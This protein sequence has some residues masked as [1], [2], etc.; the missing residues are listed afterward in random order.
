MRALKE[1][2]DH[3]V[4]T[5]STKARIKGYHYDGEVEEEQEFQPSHPTG[6]QEKGGFGASV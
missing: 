3:G 4:R 1:T 5:K 6:V 2:K